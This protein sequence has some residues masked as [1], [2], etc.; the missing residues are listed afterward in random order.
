MPLQ[1]T[2]FDQNFILVSPDHT[3][4]QAF[5]HLSTANGGTDWHFIIA[6]S[7]AL[8]GAIEVKHLDLLLEKLGPKIFELPLVQLRPHIPSVRTAQKDAIGIGV[9]EEWALADQQNLLVILH[10]DSVAGRL[11]M[12]E[13]RGSFSRPAMPKEEAPL[14][15]LG[16]WVICP[17]KEEHA[18]D[19]PFR[20]GT[21]LRYQGQQ[22]PKH[23]VFL[24][25]K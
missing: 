13:K 18:E 3:V 14:I 6:W 4:E 15:P 2:D 12:G 21:K 22:C 9:A 24:V 11:F 5:E 8:Y 23:D 20:T 19:S 10:G 7:N 16:E 25:R 1:E 17:M